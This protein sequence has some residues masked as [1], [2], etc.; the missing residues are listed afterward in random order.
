MRIVIPSHKRAKDVL[1]KKIVMDTIICVAENQFE[2]YRFFN[3]DCDVIAH[4]TDLIG[5]SPKRQ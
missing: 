2:E 1:T 4:Q 5:I 3:P